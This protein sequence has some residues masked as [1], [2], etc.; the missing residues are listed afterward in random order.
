MVDLHYTINAAAGTKV[1]ATIAGARDFLSARDLINYQRRNQLLDGDL[2]AGQNK[3]PVVTCGHSPLD[4]EQVAQSDASG[5][6]C[7]HRRWKPRPLVA[8][9][10]RRLGSSF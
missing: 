9:S 10:L 4:R 3:E 7:L 8:S 6:G 2:L 5:L 1:Q